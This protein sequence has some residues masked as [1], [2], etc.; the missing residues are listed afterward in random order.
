[1]RAAVITALTGPD[2]VEIQEV[3]EPA[4]KPNQVLIDVAYAGVVFPDVLQAR[5]EYQLRPELPFTPGWEVWGWY[6]RT[7]A[8]PGRRPGGGHAGCG[9]LGRDGR[10][11]RAHGVPAP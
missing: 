9:R 3:A 2:A 6:G 8:V 10:G 11:R 4:P 1:V 7:P 5:G